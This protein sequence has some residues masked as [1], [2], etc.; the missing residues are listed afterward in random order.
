[1]AKQEKLLFENK[2]ITNEDLSSDPQ[3][4]GYVSR[5]GAWLI[6]QYSVSAGTYLYAT[7]SSGYSSAWTGRVGLSYT[8][9]NNL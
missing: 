8:S 2:T 9:P 1:M 5:N 6:M 7:K 3:Y 4:F